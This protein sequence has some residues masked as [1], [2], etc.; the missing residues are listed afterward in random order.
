M[1]MFGGVVHAIPYLIPCFGIATIVASGVV[2]VELFIIAWI[3]FRYMDSPLDQH[4]P[5]GRR[6]RVGAL[7][8]H[9]HWQFIV[10]AR[11]ANHLPPSPLADSAPSN[12]ILLL[13][14][15][16]ESGDDTAR[17][18][19]NRVSLWRGSPCLFQSRW[20]G[21]PCRTILAATK[22]HVEQPSHDLRIKRHGIARKFILLGIP[23]I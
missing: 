8:R 14:G 5:G 13:P 2:I 12:A 17:P 20:K 16:H 22:P 18:V 9:P 21:L 4:L 7:G 1:T 11:V 10:I 3:R 19:T 6:W 23:P 15:V